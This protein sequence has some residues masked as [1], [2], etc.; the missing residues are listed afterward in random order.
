VILTISKLFGI[1]IAIVSKTVRRLINVMM[2]TASH[3]IKWL[4]NENLDLMNVKIQRVKGLLQVCGAIDCTF[5]EVDLLGHT[6]SIDYFDKDKDYNYVVQAIVD[7][8]MRF[9]DVFARF[10]G[11]IHDLKILRNSRFFQLV[12]AGSC[13]NNQK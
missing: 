11:V 1:S 10:L 13:L 2:M 9:L 3:F 5:V 4:N 6:R 8:D 7:I 12:E